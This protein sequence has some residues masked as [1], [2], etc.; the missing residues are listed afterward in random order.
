MLDVTGARPGETILV[1]GA[2][3]AVGVSVLQ[4][5]RLL[6]IRV[7]GT[8]SEP[9]TGVVMRYGGEHV[10]YGDGLEQRVRDLAG[11]PV[12][13]SLD[14]VGTDEAIDVSLALVA[15]RSRI[16]SIANFERAER[17]GYRVIMG[18]FPASAVFRDRVRA[19]LIDLA[20]RGD[21]V[22]PI[23]RTFPLSE[24]DAAMRFLAD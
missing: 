12:A 2:S 21:L 13:A 3:G 16:V 11:G 7:I 6:G 18:R 5:A 19:H 1:H 23:A 9:N 20:G 10:V 17:D 8:A 4:Q 22:V 14:C 15:D 24:A